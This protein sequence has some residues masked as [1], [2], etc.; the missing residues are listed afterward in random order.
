[1]AHALNGVAGWYLLLASFVAGALVGLRFHRE[2]L[3][4]GYASFR[5]RLLR[6]GHVALAALGI[7][8]IAY[9][10]TPVPAGGATT[11]PGT[12]LLAGSIAMPLVCFL[13]AWRSGF[14]HLFFMP[15]T[16][17]V[18]AVALILHEVQT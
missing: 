16:L 9:G 13:T 7:V 5:R 10:L 3:F 12:T 17:L 18:F 8:N 2:D 11:W 14:R 6:L 15:V 4:G 1:M